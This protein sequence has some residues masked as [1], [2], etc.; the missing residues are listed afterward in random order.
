MPYKSDIDD[1]LTIF[2]QLCV[3]GM[4][5][6]QFL[7]SSYVNNEQF[8]ED[9]AGNSMMATFAINI[10]INT[11]IGFSQFFNPIILKCKRWN[12]QRKHRN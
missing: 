12:Y 11:L 3:I 5:Y 2:N 10:L 7:C 1:N 6:L 4:L 8:K 9:V